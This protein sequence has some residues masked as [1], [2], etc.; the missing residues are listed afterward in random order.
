MS[1]RTAFGKIGHLVILHLLSNPDADIAP[2]LPV[3]TCYESGERTEF[4]T[5]H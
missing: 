2:A 3:V 5:C 1:W 4:R